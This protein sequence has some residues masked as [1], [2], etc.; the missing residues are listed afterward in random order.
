M[1][2]SIKIMIKK[3]FMADFQKNSKI[4]IGSQKK[5]V[6][7]VLFIFCVS[8]V[9]VLVLKLHDVNLSQFNKKKF[10]KNVSDIIL[11]QK[12]NHG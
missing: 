5:N 7:C 9:P 10:Y 3:K 2:Q 6:D 11:S 1:L 4:V 12:Q 8:F